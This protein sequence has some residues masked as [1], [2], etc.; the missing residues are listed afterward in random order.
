M[1]RGTLFNEKRVWR[2]ATPFLF[3][4]KGKKYISYEKEI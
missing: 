4:N 3:A 1:M 2:N